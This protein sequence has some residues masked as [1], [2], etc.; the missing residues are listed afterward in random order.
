MHPFRWFPAEGKRH[1]TTETRVPG[2]TVPTLCESTV[3]VADPTDLAWLWETCPSCD[4]TAHR[5]TATP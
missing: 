2:Q 1:A 3:V 4:S 5:M